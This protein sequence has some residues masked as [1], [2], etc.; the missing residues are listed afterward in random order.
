[1]IVGIDLGTTNSAIGFWKDGAVQLIPNS[2]GEVLT[3]SAVSLDDTGELLIG[4]AARERQASHPSRTASAFKR[5]MGSQRSTRLGERLFQPEDLSALVLR[6][7]KADAE[8]FLRE[9][10]TEAVI[11]VPAYFNDKQRKATRRAGELAGFKVERLINEPT[12]AALAYGI[13]D[14][15]REAKFLVFDLGGGTFD[16][17][18]LEMFEGV[19]EVRATTGDTRLGGEDFNAVLI[20]RMRARFRDPWGGAGRGEDALHQRLRAAAERARRE[21]TDSASA[22]MS[23]VW[24]DRPYEM[25]VSTEEF[26]MDAEPLIARLRDPVL[27]SMR[28]SGLRSEE[29]DEL[30]LVGGATRMPLVRKAATRMFGRFPASSINPDEAIVRGAAIQA[31]LKSRDSALKEVVLTDVCPYSLGV[32][33]GERQ[34]DGSIR[35]GLFSPIIERNTTIPASRVNVYRTLQDNQKLIVLNI[36]QGESRLVADNISLGQ[37]KIPVPARKAGEIEVDCRFTYDINGL[38]EVDVTVPATGEKRQLVIN[39]DGDASHEDLARRRAT[40]ATLKVHPRDDDANRAALA[41]AQ[42]C[43]ED[44]LGDTR[45]RVGHWILQFEAVLE[46][47]DPRAVAQARMALLEAIDR[48]EGES[49]L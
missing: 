10:V 16:V 33:V 48:L 14:R 18:I 21:L 20:D 49:Y 28:D 30:V 42:R 11:A 23:I 15:G 9:P 45:Q 22:T 36:F 41:R 19:M 37:V 27:R 34:A 40:L 39:D 12:A 7:L 31:G 3:P 44:F 46:Q 38:L 43:Y 25:T 29:L 17:S 1:V 8:A 24:E 47:Q 6:S 32:D 2:L 35:G 13:H 5:Y 26:E 4:R